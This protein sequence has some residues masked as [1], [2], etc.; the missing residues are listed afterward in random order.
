MLF[1]LWPSS[2]HL[3]DIRLRVLLVVGFSSVVFHLQIGM[4]RVICSVRKNVSVV[5]L[6]VLLFMF[7]GFSTLLD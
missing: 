1:S 3:K 4:M 2:I 7:V 5:L 6:S